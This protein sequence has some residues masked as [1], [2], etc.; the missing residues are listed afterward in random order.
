MHDDQD[1]TFPMSPLSLHPPVGDRYGRAGGHLPS[2][3]GPLHHAWQMPLERGAAVCGAPG[4]GESLHLHRGGEQEEEE[5]VSFVFGA[6]Y[7]SENS[8]PS[9]L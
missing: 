6:D 3:P 8:P 2:P 4:G 7:S 5:E 9:S 1:K